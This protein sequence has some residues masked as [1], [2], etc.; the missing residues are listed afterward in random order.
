MSIKYLYKLLPL[1]FLFF[2]LLPG[3]SYATHIVGGEMT[4]VCLGNDQYEVTLIVYRDCETGIPDFD[5]PAHIGVFDSN[6]QL[7]SSIGDMGVLHIPYILDDTLV[8]VLFDPCLVVPP[9]VCVDVTVYVFNV[10]LPFLAGGYRLAYQ[11]CCRNESIINI[12]G[13][14]DTGATY[15]ID[16]TEEA[17]LLCNSSPVFREWPPIYICVNEP[18]LFDHGADDIEGDSL[19]YSL[20]TPYDGGESTSC[21]PNNGNAPCFDALQPCGPI[22]C[23]PFNPPFN[24]VVWNAFYNVN[25]MLGGIPLSIDPV[26]GFMTGTPNTIGQFVVGVCLEEY[27][28]GVLIS[29]TRRDFQYNI[30]QCGVALSS[31]FA[32]ELICEGLEV[33][34]DNQS[35]NAENFEWYFNDP[36]HPDSISTEMSPTFTFSDSGTY[37]IIL[38]AEPNGLCTDTFEQEINIQLPSLF[39]E[40]DF[41]Y[42]NCTDSLTIEVTDLSYDTIVEIESW[43]WVLVTSNNQVLA[44]SAE[45]NPVFVVNTSSTV[46]LSLTITAVNGCV[47]Q[48]TQTFPANIFS[49]ETFPDEITICFG[50]E[51][52]LNPNP[53]PGV[54]YNWSPPEGLDN[55][56]SPNPNAS[57]DTTTTYVV[58][59]D[60]QGECELYDTVVVYV[61]TV[62]ADFV[63]AV[64]CD[65]EVQFTNNS[66]S[67]AENYTWFFND[68]GSPGA[69]SMEANPSYVYSDTGTFTAM[70]IA[71]IGEFCMDTAF[72]E[73]YIDEAI[74]VPDF[75]FEVINCTDS[76]T[77]ALTDMSTHSGGSSFDWIWYIS[78]GGM[79]IDSFTVQNPEIS[80]S[81]SSSYIIELLIEDED[82]CKSA[83]IQ[84]IEAQI[85]TAGMIPDEELFCAGDSVQLNP[86]PISGIFY[87]WSPPTGLSD[88]DTPS[89]MASPESST[90]YFVT[91]QDQYGCTFNDEVQ[92][93]LNVFEPLLEGFIDR[94]TIYEGDTAQIITTQNPG[95]IYDWEFS[96]SLSDLTISNPLA[97][98]MENTTYTL[99]I[100]DESGCENTIQLFLVVVERPCTDPDIFLPNAFTPNGDGE[101]DVLRLM[102]NGIEEMHLVIYNRW[103][104]KMFESFD[105]SYGW[106]GTFKG[107]QLPPDA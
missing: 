58:F 33:T 88:P 12:V 48:F 107:K 93:T 35:E 85:F 74:L 75:D 16:L 26:T 27:R 90:T 64:P 23:P 71:D 70:L 36:E 56:A 32:P 100:I 91:L 43:Y 51:T 13:P 101:N 60:N 7:V 22:P 11:R 9:N 69:S 29:T 47:Q 49:E 62:F 54:T 39:A 86:D 72:Q 92:L 103:G 28:N 63:A 44:T 6:N 57:P 5:N 61:D 78:E 34:F 45:Q 99:H 40:F 98:P 95:Y 14:D 83:I 73:F 52:P 42:A 37:N 30:G 38:I 4:Y 41:G 79:V 8:P 10:T 96:E 82:G 59:I 20:C 65:F 19:V 15:T 84:T 25:D 81:T 94:D 66:S 31:F 80:V 106:D 68:P 55:P 105:Q 67:N 53:F 3:K 87:S 21:L 1:L 2:I 104:Q 46:T 89:P 18:I 50:N 77:L 24:T 97:F 102:G 76:F 17:M